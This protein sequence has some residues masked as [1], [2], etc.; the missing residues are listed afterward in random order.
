MALFGAFQLWFGALGMAAILA[1]PNSSTALWFGVVAYG[2]FNGPT[3]GYVYDLCNR[4]TAASEKGMSKSSPLTVHVS[5]LN[6]V[7]TLH[8]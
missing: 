7:L 4:T 6:F 5:L 3:I 2:F 8:G 1:F